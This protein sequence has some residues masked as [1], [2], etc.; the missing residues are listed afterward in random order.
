MQDSQQPIP[1]PP[2]YNGQQKR[3]RWWIPVSIIAGIILVPLIL[4][5]GFAAFIGGLVAGLSIDETDSMPITKPTVLVVDLSGGLPEYAV[6]TPFSLGD[7]P[8]GPTLLETINAIERASTDPNIK[9]IYIRNGG[10]GMGMAKLTEV[11]DALVSF[12]KSKKFIYA[13]IDNGLKSH[14]YL[15]TVADSIF[16]P[17]EGML[18]FNAFGASAPFMKGLFDK[19]GVSWHVEQ[20]EEYKSAAE[21]MSRTSWSAPAKEEVRALIEQRSQLFTNAVA[22]SRSI[23]ASVVTD[24]MNRGLYLPD[25]LKKYQLIDGFSRE[26][27]LKERI[28]RRVDPTVTDAHPKLSS[29]SIERYLNASE[30][31]EATEEKSVAI[32]Y[33]SGAISEGVNK[34]A[35][36]PSGIYSRTLIK[37]L[38]AAAEDDDIGAIV[39]R[40]DS[41]GGSAYASDEI[42]AVIREIRAKKPIIASMSDVAASGGY[43]IAM[44]C[45]T[46]VTHPATITG[47]IGVIMAIPN[48]TGT[49]SMV[50]VTVDTVSLGSS[51]NFMNPLMPVTDADKAQLRELGSGI[52]KRFVAKVA[53]S[54][55][56]DFEATRLLARGR[57]WTGEAALGAGLADVSGGITTAISIAKVKMGLKSD[58]KTDI[59]TF[60]AQKDSFEELLKM[61]NSKQG[62]DEAV[63]SLASGLAKQLQGTDPISARVYANIPVGLRKQIEYSVALADIASRDRVMIALPMIFPLE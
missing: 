34:N 59:I 61:L 23:S 26:T 29:V 54:R 60:P 6:E 42:W 13:F 46:I 8:S 50:G 4:I 44:A 55:K 10:S 25:S 24:L 38:R 47:S 12:K 39:L 30:T 11:R 35:F 41:P 1:P 43:Y 18:E 3:T 27:E 2:A 31:P 9:G 19:I 16:M 40:I 5:L 36:D 33:A 56:K 48:F 57:V 63:A 20:F 32:V 51:A 52:Y 21:T 15:A 14:Y 37:D 49:S 7:Q 17:Q 22:T 62:D 58:A 28:Q 45:D 53:E